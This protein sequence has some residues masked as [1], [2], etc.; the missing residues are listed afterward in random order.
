MSRTLHAVRLLLALAAT[1]LCLGAALDR[2]ADL[3]EQPGELSCQV[4]GP[5]Q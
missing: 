5:Q 4:K 1:V 3:C 2:H